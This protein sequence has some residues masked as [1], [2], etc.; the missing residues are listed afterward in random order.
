MASNDPIASKS[1]K[2]ALSVE[3]AERFASQ[4]RPS[5]E[6]V[7]PDGS[8]AAFGLDDAPGVA[9]PA[10]GSVSKASDTI[11]EGIPTVVAMEA[12]HV[13]SDSRTGVRFSDVRYNTGLSDE[14]FSLA[15]LSTAR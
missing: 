10:A 13:R 12:H 14:A 2:P 1:R 4:I 5:W 8:A 3:D 9:A 7:G 15:S 11:I 6:L